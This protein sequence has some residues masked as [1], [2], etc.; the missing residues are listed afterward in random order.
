MEDPMTLPVYKS[1]YFV[2]AL[3]TLLFAAT[4]T[5]SGEGPRWL[6]ADQPLVAAA[7]VMTSAIFWVLLMAS[8]RRA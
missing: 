8:R 2:P 3:A 1:K 5:F 4:F 6:W 7:L